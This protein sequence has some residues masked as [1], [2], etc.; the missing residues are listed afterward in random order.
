MPT[1]RFRTF[2]GVLIVIALTVA[3]HQFGI[4]SPLERL[5][6]HLFFPV[7]KSLYTFRASEAV[8]QECPSLEACRDAIVAYARI[9]EQ[10]LVA[11]TTIEMVMAENQELRRQLHYVSRQTYV[12]VGADVVGSDV[13]IGGSTLVINRGSLDGVRKGNP[14]IIGEGIL[15]GKIARVEPKTAVIQLLTDNQ[16]KVAATVMN[17]EKSIGVVEGGYEI[18]VQM[19]MIPQHENVAVGDII[20]TSGLESGIPRGLVV[21]TVVAVKKENYQPFQQAILTPAASP[22]TLTVVTIITNTIYGSP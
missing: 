9:A 5:Y 18:S 21:G 16:S 7:S 15:V 6:R 1:H 8:H 10:A 17:A 3:L 14:V 20:V 13:S 12:T 11:T 2:L 22:R 4:L 19:N